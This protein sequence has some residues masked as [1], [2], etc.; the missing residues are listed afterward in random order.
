M[1]LRE[2]GGSRNHPPHI[3]G[4]STS[5]PVVGSADLYRA[6]NAEKRMS[7][8]EH[9]FTLGKIPTIARCRQQDGGK[10]NEP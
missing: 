2:Q 1:L 9:S 10:K 7:D 5:K 6:T 3:T 8:T 4:R